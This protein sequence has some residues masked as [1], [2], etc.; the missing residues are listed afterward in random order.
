MRSKPVIGVLLAVFFAT[1]C[2]DIARPDQSIRLMLNE[3]D[4]YLGTK[5]VYVA[6]KLNQM[7]VLKKMSSSTPLVYTSQPA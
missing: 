4:G 3:L 7:D 6:N 1:A 5:G 2:A